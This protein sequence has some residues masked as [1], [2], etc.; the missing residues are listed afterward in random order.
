VGQVPAVKQGPPVRTVKQD[1]RVSKGPG[2]KTGSQ[3]T[4]G[5]LGPM[6]VP[7]PG[8][9]MVTLG[10]GDL[11]GRMVHQGALVLVA[12]LGQQD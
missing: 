9:Q 10:R 4:E 3:G 7:G 8:D 6:E 2:V 1:P 11:R 5:I 12:N